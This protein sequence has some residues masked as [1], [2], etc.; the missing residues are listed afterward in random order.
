[1]R[2]SV[3]REDIRLRSIIFGNASVREGASKLMLCD[4]LRGA[5]S[6]SE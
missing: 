3:V 1:M 5:G 6:S 4:I 2:I